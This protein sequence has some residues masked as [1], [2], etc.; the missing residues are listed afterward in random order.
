M[1]PLLFEQ[2]IWKSLLI[3]HDRAIF[4]VQAYFNIREGELAL[5]TNPITAV[6]S[7][8]NSSIS[9][10]SVQA[11]RGRG[12]TRRSSSGI[13]MRCMHVLNGVS[14]YAWPLFGRRF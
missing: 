10:V 2:G 7:S 5:L 12:T 13:P 14:W 3:S 4:D 9:R 11:A 8:T 1:V 6:L